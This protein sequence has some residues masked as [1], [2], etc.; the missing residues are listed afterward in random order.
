[1][2]N[3]F[4]YTL[5][6][7]RLSSQ[8]VGSF[9]DADIDNNCRFFHVVQ[10]AFRRY[11]LLV[12]NT[13]WQYHTLIESK[14]PE[15]G[16]LP[17]CQVIM[18]THVH[19]I[20]YTE[21]IRNISSL[22]AMAGRQASRTMNRFREESNKKRLVR[23]FDTRPGYIAINDR[24]QLLITMKYIRDN[25]INMREEDD[26]ASYSCFD[27]WAKGDFKSYGV[28]NVAKLFNLTP[29][30]LTELLNKDRSYVIRF[31]ESFNNK[32]IEVED[33][34]LFKKK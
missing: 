17:I 22:K 30:G 1:M 15:Y 29:A 9:R 5:E 21:D 24:I 12:G 23:L 20:F 26:K 8:N 6:M 18:P 27:Y 10:R 11:K 33:K 32:T 25:D 7:M 2:Y 31:A 13:A 14:S 16:V 28:S 3:S 19:E 34:V 4:D